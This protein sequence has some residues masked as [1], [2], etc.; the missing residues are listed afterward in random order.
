M[1]PIPD[2]SFLKGVLFYNLQFFLFLILQNP[3]LGVTNVSP[4]IHK[5]D[6]IL[7]VFLVS[8]NILF[9]FAKNVVTNV[10]PHIHRSSVFCNLFAPFLQF[11]IYFLFFLFCNKDVV[12]NVSHPSIR[13]VLFLQFVIYFAKKC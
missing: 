8:Q 5:N 13:A 7:V 11:A 1:L 6:N 10:S 4:P 9:Y 3:A 2:N 12:T